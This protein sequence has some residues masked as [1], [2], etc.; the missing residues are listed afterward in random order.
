MK[1]VEAKPSTRPPYVLIPC[2]N[3]MLGKH[4][5]HV[6]GKKYADAVH[7]VAHCLPLLLP[8]SGIADYEAYL[9]L[10]DG[11]LLPGSP[12]NVH[13][14]N[15]GREVHNPALPLDPERDNVT[16]P[17][18]RFCVERAIPL[19]A[20]CRGVQEVNVALGGSL[21]QAV[22][23][24]EG[25]R[26]HRARDEDDVETQYGPVHEVQTVAGGAFERIVAERTFLVNSLHGQAIDRLGAGLTIEATAPDGIVEA[27]SISAHPGFAFGTQWH[28][29]W[30][31]ARNPVSA[32]L[33]QAFGDACRAARDRRHKGYAHAA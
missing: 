25:K 8:T 24:V 13:P 7:D 14:S 32:R 6:L 18:I 27:I 2:D 21:H 28:P 31:A 33:F 5:F 17:L 3:R 30:Q 22:Q 19:F 4:P 15:F 12:S 26:D 11:V 16:L 9:E 10:A 20:I 29:E 23:E 1:S